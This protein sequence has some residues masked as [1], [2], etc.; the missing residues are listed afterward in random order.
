MKIR[1]DFVTNSSSSSFIISCKK[2]LD[3]NIT[4]NDIENIEELMC[5]DIDDLN[6]DYIKEK[7]IKISNSDQLFEMIKQEFY[8]YEDKTDLQILIEDEYKEL[9][10]E[11]NKLFNNEMELLYFNRINDCSKLYDQISD[12]EEYVNY[13][14]NNEI[15]IKSFSH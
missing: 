8:Y 4:K 7:A 11:Y 9:F 14:N 5:L 3:I 6:W 2:N 1:R 13:A 12:F 10:E 15:I